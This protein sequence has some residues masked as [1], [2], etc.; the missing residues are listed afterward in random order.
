[1]VLFV[2]FVYAVYMSHFFKLQI[3]RVY[4]GIDNCTYFVVLSNQQQG[5][6]IHQSQLIVIVTVA[7]AVGLKIRKLV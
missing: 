4:S 7:V 5:R 2:Y 3:L 1:M 6:K